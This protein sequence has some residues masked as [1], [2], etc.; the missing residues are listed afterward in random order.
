M[1]ISYEHLPE[2]FADDSA[3]YFVRNSSGPIPLPSSIEEAEELLPPLFEFGSLT[4]QSLLMLEHLLTFVYMP[5]L[6]HSGQ[7][8][9]ASSDNSSQ[10]GSTAQTADTGQD[11]SKSSDESQSRVILRDEFLMNMQKFS[12]HISR[13]IQQLE[14]DIRLEMPDIVLGDDVAEMAK[15]PEI[16]GLL[17]ET[18]HNWEVTISSALETQLKKTPQGNGPLAEIDF[19]RE[20]N[21]TL[22]A[23]T[24]QLK[25]PTVNKVVAILSKVHSETLGSFEYHRAELTKYYTEAKDNV[26]FLSTLERHFKNLAH[27]ASFNIVL[28]TIPSMMNALRMVWIISRHYNRDERMVPLMERI[29]WELSERVAKIVNVRTILK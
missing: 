13:T 9:E 27:G 23:I 20:R 18:L 5:L 29:A 14:G 11:L 26:R 8:N 25:L 17:E 12:S 3:F 21:A 10:K 24:E 6:S 2:D 16:V 22:S 4:A 28:E 15:D 1:C 7:R 19:W